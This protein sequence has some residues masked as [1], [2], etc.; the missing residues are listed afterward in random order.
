MPLGI[1]YTLGVTNFLYETWKEHFS[2]KSKNYICII[3]K[4]K[5]KVKFYSDPPQEFE[6]D[7]NITNQNYGKFYGEVIMPDINHNGYSIKQKVIGEFIDKYRANYKLINNDNDFTEIGCGIIEVN[8]NHRHIN[9]A[10]ISY[11]V[12]SKKITLAEFTMEKII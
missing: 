2:F 12:S 4:W 11:G 9:G 1:P 3:G 10:S 7:I 5:N 6:E 8:D